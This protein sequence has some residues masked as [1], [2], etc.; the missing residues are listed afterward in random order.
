[1]EEG[2]HA[3]GRM[4]GGCRCRA[5]VRSRAR[6]TSRRE[7][8]DAAAAD[9]IR[10]LLP[11]IDDFERALATPLDSGAGPEAVA[12]GGVPDILVS[13]EVIAPRK[14]ARLAALSTIARVAVCVDDA[15]GIAAVE[16]AAEAAGIRMTA[17]VERAVAEGA[18]GASSGL[19]YTPGGFARPD[20]LIAL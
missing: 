6:D 9:V 13:N 1:M 10:E 14:L 4:A 2:A 8:S 12:W 20:E 11:V 17:L 5:T 19:E 18:C 15:A 7:W 3:A 16:Q